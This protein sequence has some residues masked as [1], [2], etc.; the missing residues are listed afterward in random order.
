MSPKPRVNKKIWSARADDN[1]FKA[2]KRS[3][4]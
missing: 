3:L 1:M 4:F 2:G